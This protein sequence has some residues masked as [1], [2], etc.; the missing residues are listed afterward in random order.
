MAIPNWTVGQVL[1]SSDVD[2]WFVPRAA[3]TTSDQ[4][5]TTQATFINDNTLSLAVDAGATYEVSLHA[6]FDGPNTNSVI[7]Q[8]TGPAGA[9]G[10]FTQLMPAIAGAST[11]ALEIP[12]APGGLTGANLTA[13]TGSGNNLVVD[14]AGVLTVGGTPG[15]MQFQWCQGTSSGTATRR[16]ARSKLT[17][18]RI[19]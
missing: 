4:S 13:T 10:S 18:R 15:T 6:V 5:I 17:I 11:A 7:W 8:F 9:A 2:I 3:V 19:S 14:V 1:A 12:L 16:R